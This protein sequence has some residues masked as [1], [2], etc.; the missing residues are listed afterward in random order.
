[1]YNNNIVRV[2]KNAISLAFAKFAL[3]SAVKN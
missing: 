2:L 1:M 3:N